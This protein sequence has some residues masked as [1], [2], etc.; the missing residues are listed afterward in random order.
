MKLI[1]SINRL[2]L[3]DWIIHFIHDRKSTDDLYVMAEFAKQETGED[4]S[5]VSMFDENGNAVN[6]SD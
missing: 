3:S 5:I 2:D 4:Y 1:K 6:L